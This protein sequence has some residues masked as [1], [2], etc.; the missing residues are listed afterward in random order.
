M[1]QAAEYQITHRESNQ[2]TVRVAVPN[3]LVK[4]QIEEIY[5][6]YA[7]EVRVPGFRKGHV[8]RS[9]LDSRFGRDVFLSE[10]QDELQR[11]HLPAALMELQLRPVSRPEMET[12]SFDE[13]ASFVFDASF[14]VLPEFSID[15]YEKLEVEAP[16][17]KPVADEDVDRAVEDVQQQFGTLGEREGDVV[18][19]EDL[20]RVKE[21]E[22]EWDTRALEDN[23]ITKH[24]IG[25][26]VGATVDIDTE[27]P[28]GK[29]FQ[30]T[31]EVVGLREI[32]LPEIDDE[33]AKDAGYDSVEALRE[34]IQTRMRQRRED[35]R[36]Q[37]IDGGLIEALLERIEIDL[38]E[39]F[40]SDLVEE[41][42][43]RVKKAIADSEQDLSFEGYL[44]SR[45]ENEETY[46]QTVR[47]G[48]ERRV[49]T[50]LTLSQ[51]ARQLE[52]SIDDEEPGKLAEQDAEG[53]GEEALRFVARL[54]AEDRWD[55]YRQNK[56]NERILATLRETAIIKDKEEEEK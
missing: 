35:V 29:P 41:E 21:G 14:D 9:F 11:I 27:L 38:P 43:D 46:R 55:D 18:A 56:V 10:T 51:L 34:D 40:I 23:P 44:E 31:L 52:I 19:N 36:N 49:R 6:A 48:M 12:V 22:Q 28:D 54:K 53:A 20:V 37:V 25:V 50:E 24:L 2:I 30:A 13:E 26:E 5:R 39:T 8:P 15:N 16:V 47:E 33:L 32:V 17:L 7:R 1:N 45:D 4:A 42:V 3:D